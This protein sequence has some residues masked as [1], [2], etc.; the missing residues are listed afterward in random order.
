MTVPPTNVITV[1]SM[2]KNNP[3]VKTVKKAKADSKIVV[4]V[5]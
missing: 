3:K 2:V 4:T 1:K 5:H